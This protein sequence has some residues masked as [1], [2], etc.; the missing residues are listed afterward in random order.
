MKSLEEIPERS[1][2]HPFERTQF[3]ESL[4]GLSQC[5]LEIPLR[6]ARRFGR[7]LS[8]G[9]ENPLRIYIG[10]CPDYSHTAG[11]YTFEALG[12]D[13]PLLTRVHLENDRPLFNLLDQH[14][15]QFEV[16]ILL[17]DV[18][19]SDGYFCDRYTGGSEAEFMSRC[20]SS[21]ERTGAFLERYQEHYRTGRFVSSTFFEEFGRDRFLNL[22]T[23]YGIRVEE[24]RDANQTVAK[25]ISNDTQARRELYRRLYGTPGPQFLEQ[26]TIRTMAQYLALGHLISDYEP[27]TMV[28][29]QTTNRRLVNDRGR[30]AISEQ[31]QRTFPVLSL[32]QS[33][34]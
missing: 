25:R 2:D 3:T 27:T 23:A 24:L 22:E 20:A 8:C 15:I 28:L 10:T 14:E 30:I 4:Q 31:E 33:V 18:E 12:D 9:Q 16:R 26:R 1:I 32:Q 13:I 6:Q 11:R 34:Y 21:V 19:G 7:M 17:A 29:H 5:G